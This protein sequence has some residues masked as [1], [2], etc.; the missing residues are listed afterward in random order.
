MQR[1]CSTKIHL[2]HTE[3]RKSAGSLISLPLVCCLK[4]TTSIVN[5]LTLLLCRGFIRHVQLG[6]Q[7]NLPSFSNC[8]QQLVTSNNRRK[9]VSPQQ[10]F[11][12][13]EMPIYLFFFS[14]GRRQD[15]KAKRRA[16]DA[17]NEELA[18]PFQKSSRIY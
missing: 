10:R 11:L 7:N 8:K 6:I 18:N 15:K 14:I 9:I 2:Q 17:E 4:L 16:I 3:K 1:Y 12:L 5:I 13:Y